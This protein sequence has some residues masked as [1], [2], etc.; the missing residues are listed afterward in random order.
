MIRVS[1]VP[2]GGGGAAE[3]QADAPYSQHQLP[4]HGTLGEQA[5]PKGLGAPSM[6]SSSRDSHSHTLDSHRYLL[7]HSRKPPLLAHTYTPDGPHSSSSSSSV[8]PFGPGSVGVPGGG[9]SAFRPASSVCLAPWAPTHQLLVSVRDTGIGIP[10]ERM[11]RLFRPFSQGDSSTTRRFGGTGLGLV[12][13]KQVRAWA[14]ASCTLC[15]PC[16]WCTLCKGGISG[17]TVVVLPCCR[18]P[19]VLSSHSSVM[20]L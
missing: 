11:S 14:S 19:V 10:G 4:T 15:A 7:T 8:G 6:F 12:I 5:H 9:L 20:H 3:S 1:A 18:A 16:S 17:C 2:M 13:S